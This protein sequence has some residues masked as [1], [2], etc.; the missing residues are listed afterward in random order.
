MIVQKNMPNADVDV[1]S[2]FLLAWKRGEI[3]DVK[4]TSV[5]RLYF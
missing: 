3:G 1:C 2:A 4:I 5:I